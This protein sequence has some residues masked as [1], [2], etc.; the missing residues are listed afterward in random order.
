M[1]NREQKWQRKWD[2]N[3]L[4]EVND[5]AE[6]KKYVLAMFPYPSG[7]LH[8]GHVRNYTIADAYARF[9]RLNDQEVLHPMGWDSFGLPAENAAIE[10]DMNPRDWIDDC[11][12]DMKE[13]MKN[14]GLSYEWSREFRTSDPSV[15]KWTQWIFIKLYE[16]D[17]VSKKKTNLNW[18]NDC[19]TVLAD[20]QVEGENDL[21]WR[22]DTPV[23]EK[24]MQQWFIKTTEYA[25]ELLEDLDELECWPNEVIEQQKNWI[26]GDQDADEYH[27]QDWL[28]SRQRYW[29]T[30][31]PL[32]NC[33]S[34]GYV[35]VSEDRLPVELPENFE[36]E[37]G[38]QLKRSEEFRSVE[39]PE[40]GDV[41]TR[42]TD[43]M[44]TFVDSSWYFLQFADN[45]GDNPIQSDVSDDWM[46]VDEYVG[47]VE[48]AT[49]HLL[50]ARFIM[51]ALE[52]LGYTGI[53]EPFRSLTTQGM[54]LLDGE[55]MSK[56]KGNV[57]QPDTIVEENGADTARWFICDA[58]A[59]QYDFN[60]QDDAVESSEVFIEEMVDKFKP[61][62]DSDGNGNLDEFVKSH[63]YSLINNSRSNYEDLNYHLVTTKIREFIDLIGDYYGSEKTSKEVDEI[64]RKTVAIV[65]YP[66][67]PHA[68]EEMVEDFVQNIG[69]LEEN[70]PYNIEYFHMILD[71]IKNI[72]E[73]IQKEDFDNIEIHCGRSWTYDLYNDMNEENIDKVSDLMK[74]TKYQNKGYEAV[75]VF[76]KLKNEN[77]YVKDRSDEI[78]HLDTL[79]PYIECKYDCNVKITDGDK[80]GI[81]GR[82]S[83]DIK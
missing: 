58:A 29:G 26:R 30:P 6:S 62:N 71:D 81:V 79:K 67:I 39:C 69:W 14:L 65:S 36:S 32:I 20:A 59:P 22:C 55:K 13:E 64:I 57:V 80:E 49:T 68:A 48:H 3:G 72:I 75:E 31:V 2:N 27:L 28:I 15:Y 46:P 66:I 16:N 12:S 21:C 38:N 8:M 19:E 11:I 78:N 61:E 47:G 17:L 63:C 18:C 1:K 45:F 50:Y 56:S 10:R 4:Y 5:M 83:I 42:E 51:H 35:T 25:E 23:V 40:C 60:W 70:T 41:A 24:S 52:D 7:K 37:V 82:P 44:D 73:V 33:E 9:C 76:N 74:R 43:T 53:S 54:V 34:C 77:T